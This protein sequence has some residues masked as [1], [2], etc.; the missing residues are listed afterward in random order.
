MVLVT[1]YHVLGT[2]HNRSIP[3]RIA[4]RNIALGCSDMRLCIGLIA[5][6]NTKLICQSVHVWIVRIV[7]GT[8]GID[9]ELFHHLQIRRNI[10]FRDRTSVLV[11]CF[12]TVCTAEHDLFTVDLY[13]LLTCIVDIC[14][15]DLAESDSLNSRLNDIA[16]FIF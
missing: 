5:D 15:A 2:V 16:V 12:M 13:L 3:D 7:A 9:V 1:L 4:G 10:F 8:D 11:I 14:F 6:V